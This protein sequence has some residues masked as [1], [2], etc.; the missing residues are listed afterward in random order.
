M[1]WDLDPCTQELAV[2]AG[3]MKELMALMGLVA[4]DLVV[5]F[6]SLRAQPLQSRPHQ[7]CDISSHTDP[8]RLSTV[9]LPLQKLFAR[10]N[11]P[12]SPNPVRL[13]LD[14]EESVDEDY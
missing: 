9:E 2:I 8:C 1:S 5:S 14:Q 4:S 10:Q 3:R 7:M 11:T 13:L 12:D 6:I